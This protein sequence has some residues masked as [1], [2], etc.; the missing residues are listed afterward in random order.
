MSWNKN[1]LEKLNRQ[2][3]ENLTVDSTGIV[4]KNH[5]PNEAS[6]KFKLYKITEEEQLF[7]IVVTDNQ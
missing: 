7:A 6:K 2:N 1:Y 3:H 4:L 5:S